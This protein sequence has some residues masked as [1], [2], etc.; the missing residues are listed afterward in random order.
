MQQALLIF[1]NTA[2][3]D[4]AHRMARTLVEQRLAACVNIIPAVRSVYR[5][6]EAIEEANE[7]TLLIK[8]TQACYQE[9]EAAIRALH[10]Y[11]V[12]EIVAVPLVAGLP[13]Y[14]NWI[15]TETKRELDV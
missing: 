5:W 6:R 3:I 2:D 1:T 14:F 10:P 4:G 13:A 9:L 12:P 8:S 11:E 7:V 15:E